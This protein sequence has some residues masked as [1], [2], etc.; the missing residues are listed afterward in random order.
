MKSLQE[1]IND[2][3][4]IQKRLA[5]HKIDLY[6][7]AESLK[8]NHAAVDIDRL[9]MKASHCKIERYILQDIDDEYVIGAYLQ[10]LLSVAQVNVN[11]DNGENHPILYACR[12]AAA[13][14][15]IPDM[16]MLFQSSMILDEKG[17]SDCVDVLIQ[18]KLTD[19][20]V[21]DALVLTCSYDTGNERKLEYIAELAALM[22]IG[23]NM[24][25]EILIIVDGVV[26]SS[27]DLEHNFEYI[28]FEKFIH[29][30]HN[31][32][33]NTNINIS[34]NHYLLMSYVKQT[35]AKFDKKNS[36][37]ASKKYILLNNVVFDYKTNAISDEPIVIEICNCDKVSILNSSF[38]NTTIRLCDSKDIRIENSSFINLKRS[39]IVIDDCGEISILSSSFENVT[40]EKNDRIS[41]DG[42]YSALIALRKA[43]TMLICDCNFKNIV[44]F[45]GTSIILFSWASKDIIVNNSSFINCNSED[46]G[47]HSL[48]YCFRSTDSFTTKKCMVKNSAPLDGWR[49]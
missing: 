14:P 9:M 41:E 31:L 34:S 33:N 28:E 13:L 16:N 26:G 7:Y 44:S 3:D 20:F 35:K 49:G 19:I 1:L 21:F 8:E 27:R 36:M 12:I 6:E 24:M 39:A 5:Q 48:I 45:N 40:I 17:I 29:I 25:N 10:L 2:A 32:K 47:I 22:N 38:E 37:F 30:F 43:G 23:E 46:M 15:K 11:D 18:H 4:D 42:M